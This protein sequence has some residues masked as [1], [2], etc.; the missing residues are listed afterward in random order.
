MSV[1]ENVNYLEKAL[2]KFSPV[3]IDYENDKV[4]GFVNDTGSGDLVI[5]VRENEMIMNFGYQNAHFSPDDVKSCAEHSRKYLENEYASVEFFIKANSAFGGSRPCCTVNFDTI[6]GILD[7]YACGNERAKN[8]VIEF[9]KK[10]S[11]VSVR[12]V[13]YDNSINTVVMIDYDGN[14]FKLTKIR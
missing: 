7:C 6:D 1:M 5:F 13:N 4:V 2:E 10:N 8:S 12:A 14:D 11:N 3:T 9:L